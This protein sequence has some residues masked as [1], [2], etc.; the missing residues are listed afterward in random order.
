MRWR[1]LLPGAGETPGRGTA[2]LTAVA[3]VLL[4]GLGIGLYRAFAPEIGVPAIE[5]G[6]GDQPVP[7][8][9]GT[10]AA[11]GW[12]FAAIAGYGTAVLLGTTAAL[13]V[14]QPRT[15]MHEIA[16]FARVAGLVTVVSDVLE[17]VLLLAATRDP[18][19]VVLE[20]AS[21]AAVTKFAGL[22][23][24]TLL[25]AYGVILTL[26]RCA[27]PVRRDAPDGLCSA[28]LAPVDPVTTAG[29]GEQPAG[30]RWRKGYR[31]PG[32][33]PVGGTGFCLSGGGIRSASVALG[34]LQPLREK[35]LGAQYLVSVSGGGYTAGALIQAL[36]PACDPNQPPPGDSV[37]T[38]ESALGPGSV[39]ED[40]VRRHVSY[41]ATTPAELLTA[42]GVLA[43]GLL[44]S[45]FLVFAPAVVLGVATGWLYRHIPLTVFPAD[46]YPA[47]RTGALISLGLTVVF[48][49]VVS[50]VGRW[51]PPA[52]V[53]F[54]QIARR[55]SS[56]LALLAAL[57]A[58][59]TLG[60]PALAWLAGRLLTLT[61][62]TIALGSPFAALLLTYV[63]TLA[64]VGW[65]NRK[66]VLKAR[67]SLDA[68]TAALP[69]SLLQR[70]LV[71]ITITILA[72]FWL[73]LFAAAITPLGEPDLLWAALGLVVVLVVLGGLIDETSLSLHPFYRERL[74]CTFAV[75]AVRRTDGQVVAA[76]YPS[77]ER[78]SLATYGRADGFPRVV[79]AAAANLTGEG[80]TS[81]GLNAVS[82]TMSS[83]WVGGPDV[84]WI[85]TGRLQAE[86]PGRFQRDLTVQGAVAISGAAFA[87]AMGRASRWYQILLA[88]SGAR[89]GT[90]L[91]NP[92]ILLRRPPR[93]DPAAWAYPALPHARRL[94]YLLREV[95]GIHSH[96]DRLLHVTDGGHY[97]NLGLVELFRRRCTTIYCIDAGADEPP[98]ASGLA[99]ALALAAQELGVR[100]TLDDPWRAEPG[101]AE[102][103]EPEHPLRA[104][105]S[106]LSD[107]P[108]ITGTIHYPAESGQAGAG[109]LVVAKAL[110]WRDLP[111]ELLSYAAHHPEFPRDGTS[112]QFF[113]D[114]KFTAYAELGR[115][116]GKHVLAHEAPEPEAVT[117][118]AGAPDGLAPQPA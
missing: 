31:L 52:R 24:A 115:Q 38:P 104:L 62:P 113:D 10:A 100:V 16:R 39:E 13:W 1:E 4:A 106:R 34:A 64:T 26:I 101:G 25:A 69:S 85:E 30:A 81:P 5:L 79:F 109:R 20:F 23:P 90:W 11:L 17:N 96:A 76:P 92:D 46:G 42:L 14:S 56:R 114:G 50:L 19:A 7:F 27:R 58:M 66:V 77:T 18:D 15:A 22:L 94:P 68:L 33:E 97:D 75:R 86:V 95:V 84:G 63:S 67:D 98:S 59:L 53:L 91:P 47:P 72:L 88:L 49:A 9:P 48:A 6:G 93:A 12:D 32:G 70:L 51:I 110:L 3:A 21:A 112:D 108:L 80:R 82:Y 78:S 55:T 41:L 73:L 28:A 102:P 107:S 2:A 40:H 57:I 37:S 116:L 44:L 111:Y 117:E 71:I 35:L 54:R 87:S 105:N 89:L 103:L 74:A 36:T 99:A 29:A 8:P 45:L 65:R 61:P 83:G 43:R 118:G 60:V